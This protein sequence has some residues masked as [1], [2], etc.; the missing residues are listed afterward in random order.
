MKELLS[1]IVLEESQGFRR[2]R[3]WY[4]GKHPEIGK[5]IPPNKTWSGDW[6]TETTITVIKP[7]KV[8]EIKN[9][10]ER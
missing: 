8:F 3:R 5:L 1:E 4:R 9:G 6:E 10:R 2:V 7:I